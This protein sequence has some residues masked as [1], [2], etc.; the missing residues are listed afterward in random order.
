MEDVKKILL[1]DD[2]RD[3]LDFL[4]YNLENAGY[5][6]RVAQNGLEGVKVAQEFLP[7]LILLDMMMPEMDGVQT[8]EEIR[9]L[10][11]KKEIVVAFLTARGEDYSQIAGFDAGADDY[12]LKPIKPKVLMSR[13]KA[14]LKRAVKTEETEEGIIKAGPLKI[15]LKKHIIFFGDLEVNLPKKE[16]KLLTLLCKNTGEVQTREEIMD[17]VWGTEVVVGDRT[18]DVHIRKLREKLG[19]ELITTIKGVGY[20]FNG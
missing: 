19:E 15:D 7:D 17:Q 3:I 18:I 20:K 2:E 6:V 8:C 1:V 9:N 14:L 11:T 16:F 10:D 4:S 13:I 5:E 12:I